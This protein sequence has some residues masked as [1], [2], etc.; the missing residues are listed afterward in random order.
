MADLTGPI[1]EQTV[2]NVP[3]DPQ[4]NNPIEVQQ[5]SSLQTQDNGG[6]G[7]DG[8]ELSVNLT[9]ANV[10]EQVNI[11]IAIDQSGSTRNSSGTDFTGDGNND[12][13]LVAELFAAAELFDAYVDAG[14]DPSEISISLITYTNDAEVRGTFSLDDRDAFVEALEDIEDEGPLFTTNYVEGLN[15]V[16]DAWRDSGVS[17]DETNVLV[18]L[19]DGFPVPGGQDI[20]GA[21]EDLEDEFNASIT[22][23]GLGANSSLDALNALDNTGGA[24][25][26]FSG[27]ELLDI[28]V[29]PLT[30]AD[31]LRFEITIEGFDENGDPLTQTIT[32][33][34]GD[35]EVVSTQLGWSVD[36]LH[37]D[38]QFQVGS[39]L[40][41]TVNGIFA[42]DPGNPG[43]GEQVVTTQHELTVVVCFTPGTQILT[44]EGQVSVEKLAVGDRVVTRD[45]G[46]QKVS[47]IGETTVSSRWMG[48]NTNLRPI[49]IR[50]GALGPDLPERDMRVSRQHRVLVRDWRAEMLFGEE[51]GVLVPAFA[52]CNDDTIIEE[53]PEG[54]VVYV[55]VAF[56]HHEIVY[57]D[58][59]EAESFHPGDR[60]VAGLS[61]THRDEL[62][63]LFPQLEQDA[64]FA[65]RIARDPVRARE[66]HLFK[67]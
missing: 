52:L 59:L 58:G 23:I 43:S 27:D 54:D 10:T 66:G 15:A 18:F 24:S 34:E 3:I 63:T 40:T 5:T 28:V 29:A 55:H 21:A 49:L 53:Q 36:C 14:Y 35:P 30:E 41:V 25:Q 20:S 48:L 9:G 26:V 11:A 56:E 65:Y 1:D 60:T 13:I 64:Q 6:V 4:S 37:L 12:S 62:Y 44:P 19:S 45:H 42:E 67:G 61:Q 57:A 51:G 33:N 2:T 38:E 22:G 47:W 17:S 16:G 31:F 7:R 50:Q 32:L 39:E 8:F 46:V